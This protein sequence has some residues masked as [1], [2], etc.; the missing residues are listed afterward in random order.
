MIV[1]YN[2]CVMGAWPSSFYLGGQDVYLRDHAPIAYQEDMIKDVTFGRT[3]LA[4]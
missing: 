4:V 1:S 2:G 3:G